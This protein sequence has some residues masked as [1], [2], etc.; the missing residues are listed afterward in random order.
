MT[1]R[2]RSA[3]GFTLIELLVTLLLLAL[4][5]TLAY[6]SFEQQVRKSRRADALAAMIRVQQA[7]E[8]WRAQQPRYAEL[9]GTA[10]GELGV[11]AD[12]PGGYYRLALATDFADPRSSYRITATA[13]TRGGQ[14]RD[15][16]CAALVLT[17]EAGSSR[18]E[19]AGCWSR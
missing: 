6:P 16:A 14:D 17:F 12:S 11:A 7:Q 3:T 15:T 19:P 10:P 5:A 4:L 13:T 8:R 1:A 2:P 18:Y 9:L